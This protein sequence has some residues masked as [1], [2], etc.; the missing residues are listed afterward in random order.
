MAHE[1]VI[2]GKCPG[3]GISTHVR[4]LL[5]ALQVETLLPAVPGTFACERDRVSPLRIPAG[6]RKR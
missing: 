2:A 5:D 6:G 3:P 4:V 1:K